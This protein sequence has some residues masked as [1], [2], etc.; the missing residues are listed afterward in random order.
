MKRV[1]LPVVTVAEGDP[2]RLE[3]VVAVDSNGNTWDDEETSFTFT[4]T[5]QEMSSVDFQVY[6][7]NFPQNLALDIISVDRSN[8]GTYTASV[9]G[10][11]PTC[12]V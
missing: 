6:S 11:L 1:S 4:N 3:F 7:S 8:E 5:Q 2:V 10:V 9:R 12:R